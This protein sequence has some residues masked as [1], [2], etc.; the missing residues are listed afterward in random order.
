MMCQKHDE[1]PEIT[2][3]MSQGNETNLTSNL[4]LSKTCHQI[5][6]IW[7]NVAMKRID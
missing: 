1:Q 3:A 7:Q 4:Y 6:H 2:K 5:Q